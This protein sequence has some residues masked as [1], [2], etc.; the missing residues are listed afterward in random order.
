MPYT[1]A[2]V[3]HARSCPK[4]PLAAELA[5]ER[6]RADRAEAGLDRIL[7]VADD[8]WK[9]LKVAESERDEARAEVERLR[10]ALTRS[11]S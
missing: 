1:E 5:R 3:E 6:E 7:G 8:Y 9:A 2:H 11:K 4:H 10:E